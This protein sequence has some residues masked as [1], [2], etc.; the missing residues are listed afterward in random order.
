MQDHD[1]N[2]ARAF[3]SQAPKFEV[4]PVQSDPAALERL[5]KAA[6]LPPG[7]LVLDAGC[8][9]GLVSAAFLAS[10]VRVV[11]VD[12]SR[13]M[14]DRARKRCQ[15]YGENARFL[16]S[17]VYDH[18]LD[19]FGPF[20]AALSRYVLHH[21]EAPARFLERQIELLRPGGVLIV[22]D[23]ITDPNP[24]VAA[25][26]AALE[27]GRDSTHTRNLSA[28]ELVDLFASAGL[29]DIR[30]TEEPFTLDFDEWFDRGT[31]SDTKD[32]VRSRLLAGPAI[33]GFRPHLCEHGAIRI[34]GIRAIVRGVKS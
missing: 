5:V 23:H 8:G 16:Q 26:H 24:T 1:E 17:S 29:T 12:L 28:G 27:I 11:G 2:L 34:D 6:A 9:P 30:Y 7:C 33:R 31:P 3:D 19:A 4:A 22:S 13:E 14:I 20:D 21:V 18:Q 10:G 25:H 15:A 32:S